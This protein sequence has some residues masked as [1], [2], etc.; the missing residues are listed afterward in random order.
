MKQASGAKQIIMA[1]HFLKLFHSQY[2]F[3]GSMLA[4]LLF[5]S[6][7]QTNEPDKSSASQQDQSRT[8]AIIQHPVCRGIRSDS[9]EMVIS[10]CKFSDITMRLPIP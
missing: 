2:Y 7:C 4:G 10:Y 9:H 6:S 5:L 3:I 1:D 8:S